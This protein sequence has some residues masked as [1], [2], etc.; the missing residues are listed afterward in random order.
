MFE[1]AG[2][3]PDLA[4]EAIHLAGSKLPIPIRYVSRIGFEG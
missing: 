1:I 2:V 4:R 3:P